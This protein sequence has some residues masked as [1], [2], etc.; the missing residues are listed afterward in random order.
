M[1]KEKLVEYL[2][3]DCKTISKQYIKDKESPLKGVIYRDGYKCGICGSKRVVFFQDADMYKSYLEFKDDI[4][5]E[6]K[7][8]LNALEISKEKNG[9]VR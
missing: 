4:T 7:T 6:E 5:K 3:L 2:C 1:D 9:R 8:I